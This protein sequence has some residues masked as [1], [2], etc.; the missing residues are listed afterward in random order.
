MDPLGKANARARAPRA[1][2]LLLQPPGNALG[3]DLFQPGAERAACTPRAFWAFSILRG[4]FGPGRTA[5]SAESEPTSNGGAEGPRHA[6][7]AATSAVASDEKAA[8]RPSL[9]SSVSV[10]RLADSWRTNC[11]N[12]A[13]CRAELQ[14]KPGPRPQSFHVTSSGWQATGGECKGMA[15][16]AQAQRAAGAS[17]VRLVLGLPTGLTE[18]EA[19]LAAFRAE[20]RR[21]E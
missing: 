19:R 18:A 1:A 15:G 3:L 9:P 14:H 6:A 12:E 16:R 2:T 5:N 10:M 13:Q 8:T 4:G 7:E 11:A 17:T 21:G 20:V